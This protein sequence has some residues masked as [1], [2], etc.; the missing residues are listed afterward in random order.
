MADDAAPPSEK[1]EWAP[2]MWQGCTLGAWCRLLFRNRLAVHLPFWHIIFVDTFVCLG[3]SVLR[4][5]QTLL[6]GR[7][8]ARTPLA[9]PPIFIV[10]HWR[11][12]TTLLHEL[13]VQDARFGFPT[14][15][16]C[17][18][19]NHF[20][21]TE[22]LFSRWFQ[23]LMPKHRPMDRMKVGFE[24]PQEDEFAMCMLGL[25]SPYLTIAF[26]N[27]PPIDQ[28]YLDPAGMPPRALARWKRGFLDFVK[29]VTFKQKKRLVLKSPPHTARIKVLHEMFPDALFVRIVRDPYVVFPS[30][31]KLWKSLYDTHGF[32]TPTFAGL[33]EFVF[34]T[35]LKMDERFEEGRR[36]LEPEQICD[37]RYE[38]LV[39]DPEGTIRSIYERLNLG[40][41][42]EMRPRLAAF[43]A[44]LRG[45]ETNK[46]ELSAEERE[47]IRRRW[48]CVAARQGYDL[49]E[50][51][52]RPVAIGAESSIVAG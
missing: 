41:W 30:T 45:Y 1:P 20:L 14:T 13:M 18:D 11:T 24:R 17:V 22:G 21:L 37:V 48:G 23:F 40:G 10:G 9:G 39:A 36:L 16:E 12:G 46:Y 31:V 15:Y 28:E 3:H 52:R 4:L 33:E 26:P 34:A 19:P 29:T 32:Q 50:P 42:E 35:F 47:A 49:S 43:T 7:A 2:R 25:P 44:T 27:R 5:V 6:F 51:G 38:N 8:I